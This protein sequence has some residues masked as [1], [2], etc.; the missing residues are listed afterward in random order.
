MELSRAWL[1]Q[2]DGAPPWSGGNIGPPPFS[3][4]INIMTAS[5]IRIALFS[6][7]Q[8]EG[9]VAF[10]DFSSLSVD[11]V[12]IYTCCP[13]DCLTPEEVKEL[14]VQLRQSPQPRSGSVGNRLWLRL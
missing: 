9:D 6:S 12:G 4:S 10:I 5:A 7:T 2:Q 1:V 3:C 11:S 13:E 14:V 8:R